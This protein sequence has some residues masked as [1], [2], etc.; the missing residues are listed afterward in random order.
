MRHFFFWILPFMIFVY[1][2]IKIYTIIGGKNK[3]RSCGQFEKDG[4]VRNKRFQIRNAGAELGQGH[5]KVGLD[6]ILIFCRFGFLICFGRIEWAE[7]N[8]VQ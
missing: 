6:F 5:I 8:I 2:I 7:Y 1:P 3:S 4:K